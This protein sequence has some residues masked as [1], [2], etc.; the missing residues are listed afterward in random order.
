MLDIVTYCILA[1]VFMT[2]AW[3]FSETLDEGR[4]PQIFDRIAELN[5]EIRAYPA[6]SAMQIAEREALIQLLEAADDF[7]P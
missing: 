2:T 4:T 5:A 7:E 1:T 3:A 6:D